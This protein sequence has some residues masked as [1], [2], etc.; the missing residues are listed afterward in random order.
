MFI[1][2]VIANGRR[3]FSVF[4]LALVQVPES[5]A[6]NLHHTS[7]IEIYKLHVVG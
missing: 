3:L 1:N 4:N 6:L 2:E 7:H 5:V